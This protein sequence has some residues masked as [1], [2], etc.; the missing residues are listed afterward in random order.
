MCLCKDGTS[1]SNE[2]NRAHRCQSLSNLCFQIRT[3]YH[4]APFKSAAGYYGLNVTTVWHP[5]TTNHTLPSSVSLHCHPVICCLAPFTDRGIGSV[6]CPTIGRLAA[7]TPLFPSCH[8]VSLGKAPRHVHISV[9][10]FVSY[11]YSMP[12]FWSFVND[13]PA[14]PE[15]VQ[16]SFNVIAPRQA[17]YSGMWPATSVLLHAASVRKDLTMNHQVGKVYSLSFTQFPRISNQT[18]EPGY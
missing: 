15:I 13:T 9:K 14:W 1:V 5:T 3:H 17:I 6:D 8:C 7:R 10:C 12:V 11:F 2:A 4:T 18:P 16:R